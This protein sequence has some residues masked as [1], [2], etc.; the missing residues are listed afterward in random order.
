M[1]L[2]TDRL[3]LSPNVSFVI[4]ANG[5]AATLFH[6]E[7]RRQ[8]FLNK[9]ALG[10]TL[11]LDRGVSLGRLISAAGGEQKDSVASSLLAIVN[12]L[13]AKGLLV[14]ED[15]TE[16]PRAK[17]RQERTT[18]ALRN[19]QVEVT[20]RCNLRC[21]HCY[22]TDYSG[23]DEF[24]TEE[25]LDLI[26][27][28]AELGVSSF[29]VTGGEPLV[30]KDIKSILTAIYQNGMYGKLYTN[31]ML[32]DDDFIRF[33]QDLNIEAVK[34]SLD[35]VRPQTHDEFR[36]AK[37]GYAR[38][39]PNI[40]KLRDLGIP[41]EV[42]TV[43]TSANVGEAPELI[44]FIKNDLG[45]RYNIDSFIPIGQGAPNSNLLVSDEQY[46]DIVK[47]E[48]T[49]EMVKGVEA[50][51][52]AEPE[53]YCGAGNSFV[54]IT[55]RGLVKFCPTMP[56]EFSG[57]SLRQASLSDIW[58]K[59]PVFKEYEYVNCKFYDSCPHARVCKGGCRSRS[60][61][62]YDGMTEPDLQ[63]CKLFYSITGV[64]SPGLLEHEA[65]AAA[66]SPVEVS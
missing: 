5:T 23:K 32:L 45:V 63:M 50:A 12:D 44:E 56:D 22:L 57:G 36:R 66:P 29:D 4:D 30:R 16:G 52:P 43:I 61:M 42:G 49:D 64:K 19:L 3:K 28:A 8:F 17:V 25:L 1:A 2:E 6:R 26:K 40:K 59:G 15:G 9:S 24:T 55:N 11:A 39:V 10:T 20:R 34:I 47:N 65:R 37:N 14:P 27:Q 62:R 33:L 31:G 54:F 38:T 41:V 7:Q 21:K 13:A 58:T 48:F 18:P 35:G 51:H 46:I 53:F 60:L